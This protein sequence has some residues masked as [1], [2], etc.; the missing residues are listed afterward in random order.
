MHLFIDFYPLI[1]LAIK[2]ET[3]T[4]AYFAKHDIL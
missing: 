2:K 4:K 3:Q 1:I